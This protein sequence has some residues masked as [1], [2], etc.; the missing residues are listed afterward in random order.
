MVLRPRRCV[1]TV[2]SLSPLQVQLFALG[3]FCCVTPELPPPPNAPSSFAT[4]AVEGNG[5]HARF[6]QRVHCLAAEPELA[7]LLVTVQGRPMRAART[8]WSTSRPAPH[9]LLST[10]APRL[11]A[12]GGEAVAY[13]AVVLSRLRAGFRF[14][15]L[16]SPLG[17]RIDLCGLLLRIEHGAEAD[18]WAEAAVLR[19]RLDAQNQEVAELRAQVAAGAPGGAPGA[20]PPLAVDAR[21]ACA[22]HA[23]TTNRDTVRQSIEEG[24]DEEESSVL[25]PLLNDSR[26][27]QQHQQSRWN[28]SFV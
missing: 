7:L 8:H 15:P 19:E 17:T 12:D 28:R 13:E 23:R 20:P 6:G 24:E 27:S 22:V 14:L 11:R 1:P 4:P 5:L 18:L 9:L 21:V 16:R 25:A 10:F 3:G 2:R 26:E